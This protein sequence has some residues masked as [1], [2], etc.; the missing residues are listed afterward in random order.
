MTV[1]LG[2]QLERDRLARR[3]ARLDLVVTELRAH[4]RSYG[5]RPAVPRPLR[6]SLADFQREL[7]HIR[8]RLAAP[9]MEDAR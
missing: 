8:R 5:D 2:A 3:A 7:D 6:H 4:A 1:T 9:A